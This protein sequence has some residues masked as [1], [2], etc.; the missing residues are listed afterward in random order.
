MHLE[1]AESQPVAQP[2]QET[3]LISDLFPHPK[4]LAISVEFS[5]ELLKVTV[6]C[7][8]VKISPVPS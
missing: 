2:I 1:D 4:Q 7:G 8:P 3:L 5:M 6:P